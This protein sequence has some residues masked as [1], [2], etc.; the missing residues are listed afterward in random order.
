[1]NS[2]RW[3]TATCKSPSA[4]PAA[5]DNASRPA[6]KT[7]A[8]IG[9]GP[10][11]YALKLGGSEDARY[12][13]RWITGLNPDK[14]DRGEQWLLRRVSKKDAV[15]VTAALFDFYKENGEANE[16]MGAF[17]RRLGQDAIVAHLRSLDATSGLLKKTFPPPFQP[18][19][20]AGNAVSVDD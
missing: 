12:Q 16:D 7:I 2:K 13:G 19:D 6:T 14:P 15:V 1:M 8:W 11:Q 5:N 10:D 9:Q 3:A 17:H 18:Y 4:S 20:Y